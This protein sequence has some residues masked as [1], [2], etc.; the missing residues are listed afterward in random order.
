MLSDWF[1]SRGVARTTLP[2]GGSVALRFSSSTDE[3]LATRRGVGVFDFSFM[4]WWEV[5]GTD[6]QACLE[7]L[8]TRDLT[9]LARGNAFY[10]LLCR[11]DGSVFIDATVWHVERNRF[12]LFTGRRSDIAHIGAIASRFDIG[13]VPMHDRYAVIAVQG[14]ASAALVKRAL[15]GSDAAAL[16]FFAF[17]RAVIDDRDAWIAR[18]GYSGELGY[19][20][21]V[22]TDCAIAM[23]TRLTQTPLDAERR[24]C[25]MEAANS[26]R[27]E[28]GYIHFAHELRGR[29][30][31]AELGLSRL[32]QT[33]RADFIGAPALQMAGP[34]KRRL[35]G[36]VLS[37]GGT[38]ADSRHARDAEVRVRLTSEAYSPTLNRVLGLAFVDAHVAQGVAVATED[39]RS[40]VL[41]GLPLRTRN[42]GRR[43]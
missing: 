7:R 17:S 30:L 33:A 38:S 5:A 14:P 42:D 24:E 21:L 31:P 35:A 28:A 11:D 6:A 41:T 1:A 15:P 9:K 34:P 43:A 12:W 8:Q 40:G 18:L 29:V 13:I 2:D 20:L 10:T 3:H 16:A 37:Q 4:G 25:G 23:W 27:I 32:V 39:E 22:P 19:E 36:V 26:L